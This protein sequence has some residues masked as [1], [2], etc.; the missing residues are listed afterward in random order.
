MQKNTKR[1]F[2][3]QQTVRLV[4]GNGTA[5]IAFLSIARNL[6]ALIMAVVF[7]LPLTAAVWAFSPQ[8]VLK[9]ENLDTRW[10][11]WIGSWHLVSDMEETTENTLEEKYLLSITPGVDGKSVVMKGSRG[12]K[13]LFEEKIEADG[14]RRP[15]KSDHC[16][17]WHSYAWSETGKRLLFTGESECTGGLQQAISG[18][19]VIGGNGDWLDFQ[20]LKSKEE[21]TITIRRYRN[22]DADA[23]APAQTDADP[24]RFA[25]VFAGTG[26][27]IDEIIELSGKVD[28]EVLEAAIVEV[29]K[30]FP[31]DSKQILH[32]ADSG[33]P[34]GVID[35]MVALSFPDKF[36]VEQ[37]TI[38]PVQKSGYL[39]V[40]L[41]VWPSDYYW[42]YPYPLYPWFWASSM[43][44]YYDYWY[45]DRYY[46]PGWYYSSWW[47]PGYGSGGY[48]VKAG[49]LVK[50]QGYTQVSPRNS[51]L[52]VRYARPRNAP[53]GQES[54]VSQQV[55]SS[56]SPY[57]QSS[58][59]SS[60]YTSS[61]D[62][63]TSPSASPRGYSSGQ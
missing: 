3:I 7:S 9:Y 2:G 34:T 11:P 10:L 50:G 12:E 51:S 38:S 17:G 54:A 13:V 62:S 23:L 49:Q 45:L 52:A 41:D 32:L 8:D 57:S 19:S 6:V 59:S 43:Y 55:S 35:L 33:V 25:R 63:S 15:M 29:H 24:A 56:S 46:W 40:P 60:S 37:M 36:I 20:L 26:F 28:P 1:F 42:S 31:I 16:S 18:I 58:I 61:E 5:S 4:K 22:L 39:R 14:V 21:K 47:Y 53:I 27:S 30:P 48:G 44:F